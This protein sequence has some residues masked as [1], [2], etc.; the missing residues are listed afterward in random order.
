MISLRFFIPILLILC[1]VFVSCDPHPGYSKTSSGIY[2]KL[3]AFGDCAPALKDA[4]YF[5]MDV[6]YRLPNKSDSGYHF[7]LHHH[8]MHRLNK[9]AAIGAQIR[10]E[11]DSMRCGDQV[12][13]I[14][15]YAEIDRSFLSAFADSSTYAGDQEI[16]LNLH[17]VR[18]F[19]EAAY[20]NYLM[21]AA[22]QEELDEAA[23]IG[24]WLMNAENQNYDQLGQCFIQYEKNV[25]GDSI[26]A[27][28]EVHIAYNTY[29]LDGTR[30]DERTEMQFSFGRP[31]QIVPGLQFGLSKLQE[32]DHA[33]IF[34][35]S[36]LAFGE[37]GNSNS[38][39][40]AHTPVY[41]DV[42]V[43]SVMTP[44]ENIVR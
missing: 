10:S 9:E 11:L 23:A 38:L 29:L 31:G 35:P 4:D 30:L 2:K 24:L 28:R 13:F 16:E 15:P 22:Q 8:S 19:D 25:S 20:R 40:P 32:G 41:F 17:L 6:S 36:F 18:T 21:R 3:I 5:I 39:V 37:D 7:L 42:E 26:M 44:S 34:L 14:L 43:V 12:S 27:G 33:R 1:T